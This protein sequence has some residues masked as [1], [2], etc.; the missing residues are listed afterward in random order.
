MP[1]PTADHQH[2]SGLEAPRQN[3]A[4]TSGASITSSYVLVS[5]VNNANDTNAPLS[6]SD[7]ERKEVK[8]CR[9]W[10]QYSD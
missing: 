4:G 2:P 5:G 10:S 7:R 3:E 8:S 9:N 6:P 1:T